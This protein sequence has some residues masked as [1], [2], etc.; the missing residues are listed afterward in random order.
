LESEY[1]MLN[2]LVNRIIEVNDIGSAVRIKRRSL[3]LSQQELALHCG[4]GTRFISDLERGKPAVQ[5]D[6]VLHVLAVL[7]LDLNLTDRSLSVAAHAGK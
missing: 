6:K 1:S 5:M 7:G 2:R 4:C 3:G